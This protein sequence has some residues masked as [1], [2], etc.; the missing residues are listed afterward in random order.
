MA[1]MV[2]AASLAPAPTRNSVHGAIGS[3]LGV[4]AQRVETSKTGLGLTVA[5]CPPAAPRA[6]SMLG[7]RIK[8]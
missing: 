1:V 5:P 2:Y 8:S 4:D 3:A 7:R 6:V